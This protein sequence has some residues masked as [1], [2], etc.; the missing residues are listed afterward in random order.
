MTGL[1]LMEFFSEK[2][3][4]LRSLDTEYVVEITLEQLHFVIRAVGV[5]LIKWALSGAAIGFLFFWSI[6]E[7]GGFEHPWVGKGF[8]RVIA[9]AYIAAW[10]V[11][12]AWA[13][14]RLGFIRAVQFLVREIYVA[15]R[16]LG[17]VLSMLVTASVR[18]RRKGGSPMEGMQALSKGL[19]LAAAERLLRGVVREYRKSD[20]NW[21]APG[22]LK[23]RW[24]RL[25]LSRV[26]KEL[27]RFLSGF[28]LKEFRE[29]VRLSRG[30]R[31]RL[32]RIEERVRHILG[33]YLEARIAQDLSSIGA[34][35][36]GLGIFFSLL[37]PLVLHIIAS[38]FNL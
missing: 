18:E 19:T 35:V 22:P 21:R 36:L 4:S 2:Q 38:I 16:V 37:F 9:I 25:I 10:T 31:I 32:A 7:F 11:F 1:L 29:E 5:G 3:E 12:P 23:E 34:K 17:R 30:R 28:L 13:G 33:A 15:E 20:F 8:L 26:K 27:M 6:Y 24:R 14:V